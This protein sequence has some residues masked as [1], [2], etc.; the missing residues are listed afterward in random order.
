MAKS[1]PR[2]DKPYITRSRVV[3]EKLYNPKYGDD[4]VCTCGHPYYRNFDTYEDMYACGCK[5]CACYEF[6]DNSDVE[7]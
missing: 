3:T 6:E 2:S 7:N 4:R 1:R 5:Y